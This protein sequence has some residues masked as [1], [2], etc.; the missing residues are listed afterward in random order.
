MKKTWIALLLAC[1][2]ALS[3]TAAFAEAAASENSVNFGD[4]S[5]AIDP[6]MASEVNE[7]KENEPWFILYPAY[8]A[9]GDSSTNFNVVWNSAYQDISTWKESDK[10]AYLE[11]MSTEIKSQYQAVGIE[12]VSFDIPHIEL[13]K[14]DGK[15]ALVSLM[16]STVKA[17]E[18]EIALYQIQAIVSI[19][20]KGTYTFT[21]TAQS[22]ELLQ[23][24]AAPLMDAITWN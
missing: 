3:C 22:M 6:N 20:D 18:Q 5:M 13:M 14:M 17:N 19:K 10:P 9:S 8:N 12:L 16:T 2:M 21:G 4:F 11:M 15:D 23:N 7:K 24:Y 1:L